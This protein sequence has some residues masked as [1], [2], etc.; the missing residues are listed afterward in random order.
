MANSRVGTTKRLQLA[1]KDLRKAAVEASR[2]RLWKSVG[3]AER[4]RRDRFLRAFLG[5]RRNDH[6]LRAGR[7]ANDSWNGFQ[8]ADAGHLQV[9]D[10]DVDADLVEGV[11]RVFR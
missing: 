6:H 11:D 10:D 3:G 2:T 1:E 8:A 9:E 7:R 5:K 4:K